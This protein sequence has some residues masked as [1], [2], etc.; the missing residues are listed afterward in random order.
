M[1][2]FKHTFRRSMGLFLSCLMLLSSLIVGLGVLAPRAH[3][4]ELGSIPGLTFYVPETIY[5][6]PSDNQ[7][8]QYFI[9]RAQ[10][11]DGALSTS[12]AATGR[13]YFNCPGATQ[14]TGLT[15][16]GATAS[17]SATTS[18]S[19]T[20]SSTINSGSLSSAIG[21]NAN[22]T[23]TWTITFKFNGETKT[24]KAYST[25]YA[26]NRNVTAN[27]STGYDHR[28]DKPYVSGLI[29]IQG[30]NN[31]DTATAVFHDTTSHHSI[32]YQNVS[33]NNVLDPL[34]SGVIT[35]ADK[36]PY[37]Y[38]SLSS[39]F[40]GATASF[41]TCDC[42][43]EDNYTGGGKWT[44]HLNCNR[45]PAEIIADTSRYTNTT[46]IPNLK[47]GFIVT[48]RE[49]NDQRRSWYVSDA[50]SLVSNANDPSSATLNYTGTYDKKTTTVN[51]LSHSRWKE[52]DYCK[53][54]FG[55][56]ADTHGTLL[57]GNANTSDNDTAGSGKKYQSTIDYDLRN[58]SSI[59]YYRGA[60]SGSHDSH[61]TTGA[62][63]AMSSVFVILKI[64][65]VN[66]SDL[67][68]LVNDCVGK[69]YDSSCFSSTTW[70][71]YSDALESAARVLGNPCATADDISTAVTNLTNKRDSLQT[72]VT[73]NL[74]ATDAVPNG[75][76][77]G[78]SYPY[79]YITIGGNATVDAEP[80]GTPT[81]DYYE[82][83]GWSLTE[84]PA[85]NA[86]A[87]ATVTVGYNNTLYAVWKVKNYTITYSDANYDSTTNPTNYNVE[88]ADFTLSNPTRTGYTFR[89]WSGTGL[90]GDSNKTVTITTGS[91]GNRTYTANWD[92]N[93]YTV[94]YLKGAASATG[95]TASQ[96]AKYDTPF[97]IAAN[98]FEY[99]GHSFTGWKG[100]NNTTYQPGQQVSNLTSV[101]DGTF[102][103]TAQWSVN[104]YNVVYDNMLD[105]QAWQ[106][107]LAENPGVNCDITATTDTGFTAQSTAGTDGYT[108]WSPAMPVTAGVDYKVI[109]NMTGSGYQVVAEWLNSAQNHIDYS[110]ADT[111]TSTFTVHENAAFMRIRFNVTANNTITCSNVRVVKVDEN[112]L[113]NRSNVTVSRS[114]KL[115][116]YGSDY[117]TDL[118]SVSRTGYE[119]A[120]WCTDYE[121]ETAVASGATVPSQTLHLWSK[122]NQI[123]YTINYNLDGG[124]NHADNPA[125][126]TVEDEVVLEQPTKPGHTFTGWTGSN[127][128]TAQLSVTI[129]KGSTGTKSYTANWSVNEYT[130]TFDCDNG[131]TPESHQVRYQNQVNNLKPANPTKDTTPEF[132]Y[133]FSGWLSSTT[134]T[135]YRPNDSLPIAT[136]DVT[137]TAQYTT[138]T[139]RYT[140]TW[141]NADGNLLETDSNVLYNSDPEYNGATPTKDPDSQYQ[142]E[143]SGWEL[144]GV[145]YG[146]N[147]TL[148]KVTGNMTFTA[149]YSTED[150]EYT[151]TW[152]DDDG[153]T[154]LDSQTRVHGTGV[155]YRGQLPT[156]AGDDQYSYSFEAFMDGNV[157]RALN[158]TIILDSDK[159]LIAQYSRSVNT[160][161]VTW[162][163]AN[164]TLE[165]DTGVPYGTQP[166]FD[167]YGGADPT[168]EADDAATYEFIGWKSSITGET[169]LNVQLL[170]TVTGNVT[171]TAQFEPHTRQY[172]I[173]WRNYNGD[174]L[175]ASLVDY[176]TRPVY[177]GA[178]PF[179]APSYTTEY[180]F[181]GWC[182]SGSVYF[183]DGTELP[184][185]TGEET[186]TAY[187]TEEVR[188]YTV[189]WI[190]EDGNELEVD[191]GVYHYNDH[192]TFDDT[193]PIPPK[194]ANAAFTYTFG[195]WRDIISGQSYS[196]VSLGAARV[197]QDTTY[198]VWYKATK[199]KYD[200]TWSFKDDTGADTIDVTEVGYGDSPTHTDPARYVKNE[201]GR[202]YY[203]QFNGWA[204]GG[205]TYSPTDTLPGVTGEITYTA[206]YIR[207]DHVHEYDDGEI[208][209]APTCETSGT[210][211]R[212]C[213]YCDV[214]YVETVP[215]QG[216]SWDEG[217][218]KTAPSCISA[219]EM[220]YTC[221]REGCGA[222][223]TETIPK[224]SS[225]HKWI[226]DTEL[227][228]PATCEYTGT[229]Y[230]YCEHNPN[231]TKRDVINALG[232]AYTETIVNPTCVAQGY[233]EY[234]CSRCGR[235]YRDSYT[236]APGHNWDSNGDGTVN[237][238]DAD[239]VKQPDCINSG[240]LRYT[241]VTCG[242]TRDELVPTLETH[243]Y[244]ETVT[245]EATCTLTE[246]T[247]FECSVCHKTYS[248]DTHAALGHDYDTNGDGVEDENDYVTVPATCTERG[249]VSKT[250]MRCHKTVRVE[251]L[252][253]LRHDWGVGE[254]TQPATCAADGVRTYTCSRCHITRTEAIPRTPDSHVYD[255]GVVTTPPTYSRTGLMTYTCTVCGHSYTEEIGRLER[256]DDDDPNHGGAG[257][258]GNS[259]GNS[260]HH[261]S[262]G[263]CSMCDKYEA[264]Q[265]SN[266][267]GITKLFYS[268]VHFIVHLFATFSF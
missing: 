262:E 234:V 1:S 67:R 17:L 172:N 96:S 106:A 84:N 92:K 138:T 66:K 39:T 50:T 40:D 243:T 78:G 132:T 250:C 11:V 197:T 14:V 194:Q 99:E 175:G 111:Q 231:H 20:L 155:I 114:G 267:P 124:T 23:I 53:A 33:G 126:Y 16:S 112:A 82:F 122:W 129:P 143:W 235:T 220:K 37:Y 134:G 257:D 146:E 228:T 90:S 104:K 229:V 22:T 232:H 131:T 261:N 91:H 255:G 202:D 178:T 174:S 107:V 183:P 43:A 265:S 120:G 63:Y 118:P 211:R 210:K 21:N 263:R 249:S 154:V 254:V 76:K 117:T 72:K 177:G 227:S 176:G 241:C 38:G 109:T 26:P 203:Y 127:G 93:D 206:T 115:F 242:A 236:D 142:Y 4:Q 101:A 190:D 64:T 245:R 35:Q 7:T 123:E 161:T 226:E 165:T 219:G 184:S 77:I 196:T 58:G 25:A 218:I 81:R 153:E 75:V 135:L 31:T 79:G 105:M 48:D 139:N 238:A 47:L 9:D 215:A 42:V 59:R 24:A 70:T 113:L 65:A 201:D 94:E 259:G 8:F 45:T 237:T 15:V 60:C 162:V 71:N 181:A 195:G 225:A 163:G 167:L 266:S 125:K 244:D 192:P 179:R 213:I 224:D 49:N 89:G 116:N 187:Y 156:K 41:S 151:I 251:N 200:V 3:A 34:V 248:Q 95:S 208:E 169:I 141:L 256:D 85:T 160:Y 240:I 185:V 28:G 147:D 88:T 214:N 119:F 12:A 233:T 198:Q 19:S 252:P 102:T 205:T 2:S 133:T 10:S 73:L 157:P 86:D 32:R 44:I 121:A 140:V 52:D 74:G 137:Y 145:P 173:Y 128:N 247:T 158:E 46:Q 166:S 130:I 87:S 103:M 54:L 182:S 83:K 69:Y 108:N 239:P 152:F 98:G 170:N 97:N 188:L 258:A 246:K 221:L 68:T 56:T 204:S 212:T 189:R 6:N 171:F 223:R 110:T 100:Q 260:T 30:A 168:K 253:A 36:S 264:I 136:E 18:S 5:L 230:S 62:S 148:P 150:R 164:G 61:W 216:H 149:T 193:N 55:E 207:A 217:E 268:I 222:T 80:S 186:Y 199:V 51:I 13:I 159:T 209:I 180:V 144:N 57:A 27:G 29:F 191:S